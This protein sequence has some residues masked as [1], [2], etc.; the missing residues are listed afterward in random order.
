VPDQLSL[1]PVDALPASPANLPPV[2][3]DILQVARAAVFSTR[4]VRGTWGIG[5]GQK[6]KWVLTSDCCCALSACLVAKGAVAKPH[7]TSPRATVLR[8]L[9]LTSAQLDAF[10]HGFDDHWYLEDPSEW[11][12]YGEMVAKEVVA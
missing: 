2:V 11:Y 9:G 8:V 7:E 1:T 12:R 6:R 5:I 10:V 3:A 4:I